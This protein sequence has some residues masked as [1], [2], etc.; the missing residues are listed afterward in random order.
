MPE[1]IFRTGA[2]R[3]GMTVTL[4]SVILLPIERVVLRSDRGNTGAWISAS[5]EPYALIVR[6]AGGIRS[7]NIDAAAGSFEELRVGVPGLD[8]VLAAM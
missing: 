8:A 7:I 1:R 5:M 4:G 2:L 6:D 3:A